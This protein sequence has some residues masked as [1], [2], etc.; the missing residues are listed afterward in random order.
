MCILVVDDEPV[1]LMVASEVLR[2]AGH[3][4]MTARHVPAALEILMAHPS[5]FTCLVTDFSMPG[6]LTGAHLI[7]RMRKPY[8]TIPVVLATGLGAPVTP[9]WCTKHGVEL[10]SKPYSL[11]TLVEAV[12]RLLNQ[13]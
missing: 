3:E 11:A 5:H 8:P 9:E 1:T 2:E 12:E 4:V 7:E 13:A 6:G 10:L